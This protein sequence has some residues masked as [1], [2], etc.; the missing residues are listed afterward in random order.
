MNAIAAVQ[1]PTVV[2]VTSSVFNTWS[3]STE[4][5]QIK[6]SSLRAS[7]GVPRW[8]HHCH[9]PASGQVP[10]RPPVLSSCPRQ[11]HQHSTVLGESLG[12]TVAECR[13]GRQQS[14]LHRWPTHH[15]CKVHN[16]LSGACYSIPLSAADSA[17]ATCGAGGWGPL[18]MPHSSVVRPSPAGTLSSF[19]NT[20]PGS[21]RALAARSRP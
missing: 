2:V 1:A 3:Q 5:A 16:A 19:L 10:Q 12:T 13:A 7:L 14:P 11:L 17:C 20:L 9:P 4:D 18:R 21:Y 6:P 8:Q 15:G